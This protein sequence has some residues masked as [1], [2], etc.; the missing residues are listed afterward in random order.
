MKSY[1]KLLKS[2]KENVRPQF[3]SLRQDACGGQSFYSATGSLKP[4]DPAIL[5]RWLL[6]SS[7]HCR[8]ETPL[9]KPAFSV[10]VDLSHSVPT[11]LSAE[12]SIV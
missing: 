7:G 10:A 4:R 9:S 5:G 11:L 2:H 1:T 6:T 12:R 8:S 3:L